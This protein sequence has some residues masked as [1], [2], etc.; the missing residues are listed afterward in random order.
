ME[1]AHLISTKEYYFDCPY[2]HDI[3]YTGL[4]DSFLQCDNC[5]KNV[6]II[7]PTDTN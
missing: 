1:K 7:K 5:K 6:K 4:I 3:T 2:C